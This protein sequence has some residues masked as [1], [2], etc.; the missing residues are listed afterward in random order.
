MNREKAF[1]I[2]QAY[3]KPS[4]KIESKTISFARQT[5]DD[6]DRIENM[7]ND[8][9]IYHYKALV[10]INYIYGQVSLNDM[11]RIDLITLELADRNIDENLNEWFENKK[12]EFEQNE[13]I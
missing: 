10:F 1:E 13:E 12:K 7:K 9:L 3:G 4:F 11:Q 8:E 6:I 2:I 5:Q